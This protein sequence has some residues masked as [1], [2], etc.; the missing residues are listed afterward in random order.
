MT[1]AREHEVKKARTLSLSKG[2]AV[3]ED[4]GYTDY[5]WYVQLTAQKIFFVTRQKRHVRYRVLA[6]RPVQGALGLMSDETI[7]PTGAKGRECPKPL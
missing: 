7:A 5:Y 3:V 4:L 2:S 6:Q 1:P